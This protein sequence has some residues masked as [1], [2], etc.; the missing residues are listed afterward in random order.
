MDVHGHGRR[1]VTTAI[2]SPLV[3]NRNKKWI[4]QRAN[5][6]TFDARHSRRQTQFSRFLGKDACCDPF[7]LERR[8]VSTPVYKWLELTTVVEGAKKAIEHAVHP[9]Q[10]EVRSIR[11][12]SYSRRGSIRSVQES[13]KFSATEG[14]CSTRP[15]SHI[16]GTERRVGYATR[17]ESGLAAG[18]GAPADRRRLAGGSALFI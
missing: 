7:P 3:R 6:R 1:F 15:S 11:A 10:T 5:A 12:T 16:C 18:W 8:E 14:G 13:H 2:L 9:D 4:S 17:L